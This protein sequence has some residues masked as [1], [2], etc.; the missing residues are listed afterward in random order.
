MTRS[1]Y[2]VVFIESE[3]PGTSFQAPA[4]SQEH[5]RNVCHIAH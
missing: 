4:L 3:Q 1:C 2:I 5:V